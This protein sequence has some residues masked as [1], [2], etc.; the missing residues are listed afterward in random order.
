M[1]AIFLLISIGL[2]YINLAGLT[3][4]LGRSM[5]FPIARA[6]GVLLL[7]VVLFFIEHFIGLGQIHWFWPISTLLAGIVLF[8]ERDTLKQKAF[9]QSELVF[10]LAMLY[11]LFWKGMVPDIYPSSERIT[12]LYF[13]SNYFGGDT[14]PP[15]DRWYAGHKF[16]VYYA[17][18]QYAASLLGRWFG[19]HIGV[20][21]NIGFALLMALSLA[22][23]WDFVQRVVQQRFARWVLIAALAVGG[24]GVSPLISLVVDTAGNPPNSIINDQMWASARF[25]GNYD[26]RINTDFGAKLFPPPAKPTPEF[27]AREL[28]MENFGYQFFLGDFHPP[29]GGF[30]LL[31]FM[32]ALIAWRE[33]VQAYSLTGKN[34]PQPGPV[35]PFL[36]A[37]CGPAMLM[38]NTW[39]LPMQVV[40][41]ASW[42]A[43]CYWRERQ[44]AWQA[45]L[46]G[47]VV[48][49]MLIYPFLSSFATHA[50]QTPLRFTRFNDLTDPIRL[51]AVMW[52]LLALF[53][54][55][56]VDKKQRPLALLF[57]VAF[58]AMLLLGEFTFID[59]PSGGKYERTNTTMK[60]W[61]WMWSGAL[62]TSGAMALASSHV[63]VRRVTLLVLCAPLYALVVT[64][65]FWWHVPKGSAGRFDGTYWFSKERPVAAAINYLKDA[66]KGIVLENSLGDS[67]TNQTLFALY[68]NQTALL[69]WP[70]HVSLWHDGSPDIWLLN[71][72][73][74]EFYKAGLPDPLAW[75][76]QN[77]VRYVVWGHTERHSDKWQQVNDSISGRYDWFAFSN[78]PGDRIGIWVRR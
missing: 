55:S 52:P 2:L 75:L 76:A 30:F 70:H 25:I 63:W 56:L 59:D 36:L 21:Y 68:S 27:E 51:F 32:L 61:G 7:A 17:F 44:L 33:Q 50:L 29:L 43:W 66:P 31:F 71:A 3:V 14:L 57:V 46:A 8:V 72:Q 6:T 5:P 4:L 78:Q 48:G 67:F 12:D 1:F 73:I 13:M 53:G 60:W 9:I 11:A 24:T 19:W 28:P 15:P 20:S 34:R 42:C 74:K 23:A 40:L 16:D 62:L 77:N 37:L 10:I 45:L 49:L 38:T 41:L 18:Q 54:L 65:Q 47:G 26:Q 35:V 22:L 64:S 39:V 69:G 58:G